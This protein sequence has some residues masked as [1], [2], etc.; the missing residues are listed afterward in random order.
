MKIRLQN[1]KCYIDNTFDFGETGLALLSGHSGK[2][3]S[4]IIQGIHFALFGVGNKIISFGKTTCKVE[5]EFD[6]IKIERSKNPC[7]LVVNDVYEDEAGQNIID[8]KFGI[9]F[10][11]T[12]YIPQNAIKSFI[13]MSAQDKLAFIEK[14]AFDDVKLLEMKTKCKE[15][16]TTR[17]AE[18]LECT[19][20]LETSME[21]LDDFREPEMIDF[22]LRVENEEYEEEISKEKKRLAKLERD[23]PIQVD[24]NKRSVDQLNDLKILNA[25]L[26]NNQKYIEE[27]KSSFSV[28][29]NEKEYVGDE[30]LSDYID[31]LSRLIQERE[32]NALKDQYKVDKISL[33]KM[34]E[35]E[36]EQYSRE[37]NDVSAELWLLHSKEEVTETINSNR[38]VLKDV[39]RIETLISKL[40]QY[41]QDTVQN[42]LKDLIDQRASVG[43]HKCPS[44]KVSLRLLN[45]QLVQDKTS[46]SSDKKCDIVSLEKQIKQLTLVVQ[47]ITEIREIR[48]SYEDNSLPSIEEINSD[49]DYLRDYEF[50]QLANEKRKLELETKI[51]KKQLSPSCASFKAKVDEMYHKINQ[52]NAT[53]IPK[54]ETVDEDE[55]R[56]L[57]NIQQNLKRQIKEQTEKQNEIDN[58]IRRYESENKSLIEKHQRSYVDIKTVY[59]L[60]LEIS[61]TNIL[62]DDLKNKLSKHE[63]N[64]KRIEQWRRARE[65]MKWYSNWEQKVDELHKEETELRNQCGALATLR[66]SILEAESMVMINIV[67][68]INTHAKV[69]LDDF[70]EDD[71]ITVTLQAFKQTKKISKAQLNLDIEYKGMECDLQMLSGGEMSRIVLAY[72]LALAEMFNTPL[73]ML[74]E[75]TAS[76]DQE[77]ANHVFDSIKE[78]FNGKL[79]II[80]AHQVVTGIFDRSIV[81]D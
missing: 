76:L 52:S 31:H 36:L 69:Y 51:A 44:C 53:Q 66:E 71:P 37:L 29:V 6:G 22:P 11:V 12:G 13:L 18:L 38:N 57:I 46:S 39:E 20:K 27:I 25:N 35:N 55:L 62:I 77:T 43:I 24:L 14:F 59:D 61:N 34:I 19:S 72:T 26:T 3:K 33:D 42:D 45:D 81:I 7:K 68:S 5:L 21:M 79:T 78:H 75:C 70:F 56:S 67:D 8:N 10:D 1:I 74:D 30:I 54:F 63:D 50:N 65:D 32:I 64:L 17:H 47:M 4:S 48:N 58:K 80:V 41:N 23:I 2:G 15:L 60:E 49:L 40:K 9:T 73:L 16:S 28:S